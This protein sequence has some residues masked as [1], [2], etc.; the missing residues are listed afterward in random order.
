M[1]LDPSGVPCLDSSEDHA[2]LIG[3]LSRAM[4]AGA[5]I[6][7]ELLGFFVKP[8]DLPELALEHL[9]T[10]EPR[11]A[12]DVLASSGVPQIAFWAVALRLM[13]EGVTQVD[14]AALPLEE[15]ELASARRIAVEALSCYGAGDFV[16]A[17]DLA[18]RPSIEWP[19]WQ[20]LEGVSLA[21]LGNYAQAA[22]AFLRN[23]GGARCHSLLPVQLAA[24]ALLRA[25]HEL[26]EALVATLRRGFATAEDREESSLVVRRVLGG[27][28]STTS[29]EA[30]RASDSQR[31]P[32]FD[33]SG[34]AS[35]VMPG[36]GH[37]PLRDHMTPSEPTQ[38]VQPFVAGPTLAGEPEYACNTQAGHLRELLE[39]QELASANA[40]RAFL[41]VKS[42]LDGADAE[43]RGC[44]DR[45]HAL[46]DQVTDAQQALQAALEDLWS[47]A[48]LAI[49][50]E[51]P[52]ES[53]GTLDLARAALPLELALEEWEQS[54]AEARGV[55]VALPASPSLGPSAVD[56]VLARARELRSLAAT[57]R[58]RQARRALLLRQELEDL[59]K[60]RE[61]LAL[62]TDDQ[63]RLLDALSG[64][65]SPPAMREAEQLLNQF[66]A[67]VAARRVTARESAIRAWLRGGPEPEGQ[68]VS[69]EELLRTIEGAPVGE[70]SG[71]VYSLVA[72]RITD[73]Q[74]Q[75]RAMLSLAREIDSVSRLTHWAHTCATLGI[76]PSDV[77]G[78]RVAKLSGDTFDPNV[79][80]ATARII[81]EVASGSHLSFDETASLLA[82]LALRGPAEDRQ[83][84]LLRLIKIASTDHPR[85][86]LLLYLGLLEGAEPVDGA[87]E[88]VAL[89]AWLRAVGSPE[90]CAVLDSFCWTP[91]IQERSR[92]S[93]R[94]ALLLGTH[95]IG[96]AASGTW[97]TSIADSY[98]EVVE[99]HMPV[100]TALLRA[101]TQVDTPSTGSS[102]V[103][104][105]ARKLRESIAAFAVFKAKSLPR[106]E[107][108][109][110]TQVRS[111]LEAWLR[112]ICSG[113]VS[114]QSATLQI[115]R[116]GALE[117]VKRDEA[118]HHLHEGSP[119]WKRMV[120]E[121]VGW[122]DEL[123]SISHDLE[124]Q[125]L[126]SRLESATGAP[127][128]EWELQ[129]RDEALKVTIETV[130]RPMT[131]NSAKD[132]TCQAPQS[133]GD[134]I[135]VG[136]DWLDGP[137]LP[138]YLPET[139]LH[140][141]EQPR[142]PAE[143][144]TMALEELTKHSDPRHRAIDLA[145]KGYVAIARLVAGRVRAP[146]MV[147]SLSTQL[148]DWADQWREDV[149]ARIRAVAGRLSKLKAGATAGFLPVEV[150]RLLASAQNGI[151]EDMFADADHELQ[152]AELWLD[153]AS[154]SEQAQVESALSALD[155]ALREL[156]EQAQSKGVASD[157]DRHAAAD[158]L[159][160]AVAQEQ[161]ARS[162]GQQ[163]D[164]ARLRE[165][166]H[167]IRA[168]LA[169]DTAGFA[170]FVEA[171]RASYVSSAAA[172]LPHAPEL[173]P[174]ANVPGRRPIGLVDL[175]RADLLYGEALHLTKRG[176][177]GWVAA[178][179]MLQ[180]ILTVNP[181]HAES[182]ALL[183]RCYIRDGQLQMAVDLLVAIPPEERPFQAVLDLTRALRDSSE[184]Q[185]ALPVIDAAL[186]SVSSDPDAL[187]LA[188]LAIDVALRSAD[189]AAGSAR[190]E[191]LRALGVPDRDLEP[192]E[193]LLSSGGHERAQLASLDRRGSDRT[194]RPT[195]FL[196]ERLAS[197]SAGLPRQLEDIAVSG[198]EAIDQWRSRLDASLRYPRKRG[199]SPE[200]LL[201]AAAVLSR[202][203]ELGHDVEKHADL[204]RRLVAEFLAAQGDL[205]IREGELARDAGRCLLLEA[206]VVGGKKNY[207]QHT[208][209]KRALVSL[210]RDLADLDL[211]GAGET[212][213]ARSALFDCFTAAEE[214]L[215]PGRDEEW[216]RM[217]LEVLSRVDWLRE[218]ANL[219][220]WEHLPRAWQRLAEFTEADRAWSRSALPSLIVAYQTGR[221]RLEQA[222]RQLAAVLRR[223]DSERIIAASKRLV[224]SAHHVSRRDGTLLERLELLLRHLVRID[225]ESV[226]D[227]AERLHRRL[228][229]DIDEKDR[230]IE[231]L[232]THL[233][234]EEI[235][236]LLRRIRD[237]AIR[238]RQRRLERMS[239]DLALTAEGCEA[240][241]NELVLHLTLRNGPGRASATACRLQAESE[242]GEAIGDP[243]D[244]GIVAAD[245]PQS[246][247]LRLPAEYGSGPTISLGCRIRFHTES[248]PGA[249]ESREVV[250]PMAV[251][252]QSR[253]FEPATDRFRI[254]GT[255]QD[256]TLFK[257]RWR[258]DFV[259][260]VLRRIS[261]QRETVAYTVIGQMRSG[262]SS[263][264]ERL[265]TRLRERGV[266]VAYVARPGGDL[267]AAIDGI[268]SQLL[269]GLGLPADLPVAIPG[270]RDLHSSLGRAT[271]AFRSFF[272]SLPPVEPR[273]V[274]MIDE[275]QDTLQWSRDQSEHLLRLLK[276]LIDRHAVSVVLAGNDRLLGL[277]ERHPNELAV[278]GTVWM[279]WF[280]NE[281]AAELL[282][283]ALRYPDGRSRFTSPQVTDS[284]N[285]LAGGNPWHLQYLGK[286]LVEF[287]NDRRLQFVA[288]LHITDLVERLLEP[289]AGRF[290]PKDRFHNL[291][292]FSDYEKEH[293]SRQESIEGYVLRMVAL[294]ER[295]SRLVSNEKLR[296][297]LDIGP[298]IL[299]A[300]F[301]RCLAAL[302][303]RGVLLEERKAY[304]V[305][306][307][308]FGE[309]ARRNLTE[310][311]EQRKFAAR[312]TETE[313]GA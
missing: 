134:R 50:A 36:E 219:L 28:V 16:K 137:A 307:G 4:A 114:A 65:P 178:R 107:R 222:L 14:A 110:E 291:S 32:G 94:W 188:G 298:R 248:A 150:S 66:R 117:W 25:G 72:A 211:D 207:Q 259:E 266:T 260:T 1:R 311:D 78:I 235:R 281:D 255:L 308:L 299:E 190:L 167:G 161:L 309:W 15:D 67:D 97:P 22:L 57:E 144:Q 180:H 195:R 89:A 205:R 143:A 293:S 226:F 23:G 169:N 5:E 104:G 274:L 212:A 305:R 45:L 17:A 252:S 85:F 172:V 276:E 51:C 245:S 99:D 77:S 125:P 62:Q 216:A 257:G 186:D 224:E 267:G 136:P 210:L 162:L 118:T 148:E 183:A 256:P 236:P 231:S 129:A 249:L 100:T 61:T 277:V 21:S 203:R 253:P 185:A 93:L 191:R 141:R 175:T 41:R 313:K 40:D 170:V 208:F 234:I 90:R 151:R 215:Q 168:L 111:R 214:R 261:D 71:A 270:P 155:E 24:G 112:D 287:I 303:R 42:T 233:G 156:H 46:H 75:R 135:V 221:S 60:E 290:D 262:K 47:R 44:L 48:T 244:V 126:S 11:R 149:S 74:E 52:H 80:H 102:Q 159:V 202:A 138:G 19:A 7:L 53:G 123:A 82:A 218:E 273:A 300:E 283:T 26:P 160:S 8:A 37:P 122:L 217:V 192:L 227:E 295:G 296:R 96:R 140:L 43:L 92:S 31:N 55:G 152:E 29:S 76:G 103:S 176:W 154:E 173:S 302:V 223:G 279:E 73:R 194:W 164:L 34:K 225:S 166:E 237:A 81:L 130:I 87:L 12:A 263:L 229:Q 286:I 254:E 20:L 95:A 200:S 243:L 128:E 101:L 182:R 199:S 220:D 297:M 145:E 184:P 147:G 271:M 171:Q 116:A 179:P 280:T 269:G 86:C 201:Q 18:S 56:A 284:L 131:Q 39:Q 282:D 98:L 232:P 206:L 181:L 9:R 272:S 59:V 310:D 121:L 304:R 268:V 158:Y 153:T 209:P 278:S 38:Q 133:G 174:D 250:L 258:V 289:G 124:G 127:E 30:G 240:T 294:G 3:D 193:A 105:R 213:G 204:F 132:G 238:V 177:H 264:L 33:I 246:V 306:V 228:V 108:W 157:A 312:V 292:M 58:A 146:E 241:N 189:T 197:A 113:G 163:P 285:Q 247:R 109:W 106:A 10:D 275:L 119:L 84:A 142:L 64:Q 196:D 165:L 63:T 2:A 230:D 49:G 120:S 79:S 83:A 187:T 69:S 242:S 115:K 68:S 251:P 91:S 88:A 13:A 27:S 198:G 265:H 70:L 288:P 239:P 54:A 301:D 6:A 35:D 139:F